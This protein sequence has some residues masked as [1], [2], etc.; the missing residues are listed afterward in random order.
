MLGYDAV[1]EGLMRMQGSIHR[2]VISAEGVIKAHAR[3]EL[4]P[5]PGT[6]NLNP[7]IDSRKDA[8]NAKKT[9]SRVSEGTH[10]SGERHGTANR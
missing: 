5:E 6:L 2:A 9:E 3:V 8:K 1:L 10:R 4:T 7:A